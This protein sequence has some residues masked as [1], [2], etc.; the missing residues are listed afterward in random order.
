M[1]TDMTLAE[2]EAYVI[3]NSKTGDPNRSLMDWLSHGDLNGVT[4]DDVV[5]EWDEDQDYIQHC[6]EV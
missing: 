6:T 3:R 1:A 2:L 4:V 5:A